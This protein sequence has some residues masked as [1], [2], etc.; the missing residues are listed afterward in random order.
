MHLAPTTPPQRKTK[1][2][3]FEASKTGNS[4]NFNE[5]RI[6]CSRVYS[7]L[8]VCFYL[9]MF[10]LFF[11]L[12]VLEFLQLL[13]FFPLGYAGQVSINSDLLASFKTLRYPQVT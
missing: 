9:F 5:T 3:S 11:L 6:S 10:C 8:L 1:P 13:F 4:K 7:G 2:T 12:F